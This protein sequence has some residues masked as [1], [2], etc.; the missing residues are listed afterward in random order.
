MTDGGRCRVAAAV[1]LALTATSLDARQGKAMT[2]ADRLM[3]MS[4]IQVAH[5]PLSQADRQC[6]LADGS[7]WLAASNAIEDG[8]LKVSQERFAPMLTVDVA[9]IRAAEFDLCVTS[10]RLVLSTTIVGVPQPSPAYKPTPG[11]R[12]GQLDVLTR[13]AMT[14]SAPAGHGER[15]RARITEL[16]SQI[17]A[18]IKHANR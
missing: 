14:W 12:L 5:E 1:M 13:Q 3:G 6:G 7:T 11:S 18:E 15:V 9:T 10:L 8:G 16:V 4:A 2:V 17:V